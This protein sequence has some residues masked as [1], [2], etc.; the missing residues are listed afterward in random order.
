M[1][2]PRE[3]RLTLEQAAA[4]A[5]RAVETNAIGRRREDLHLAVMAW[6]TPRV[7]RA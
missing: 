3:K 7:G 2:L 6:L 5:A 1:S 4:F